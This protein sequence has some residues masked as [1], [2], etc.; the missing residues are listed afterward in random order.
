MIRMEKNPMP[1]RL[2]RGSGPLF[3]VLLIVLAISL[4]SPTFA[5]TDQP[6]N[7]PSGDQSQSQSAHHHGHHHHH[8][9]TD[10]PAK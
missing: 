5:Q 4:S 10:D 1:S 8:H 3:G 6:G 9:S 2:A 7:A